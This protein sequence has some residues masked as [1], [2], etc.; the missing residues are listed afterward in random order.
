MPG[1][2]TSSAIAVSG[3]RARAA[4]A[5]LQETG[6]RAYL[7]LVSASRAEICSPSGWEAGASDV[8]RVE[9]I[10]HCG[11]FGRIRD[12][13]GSLPTGAL[14]VGDGVARLL[15]PATAEGDWAWEPQIEP[16]LVGLNAVAIS[17]M[18]SAHCPRPPCG[19]AVGDG[20]RIVRYA[21]ETFRSH[22]GGDDLRVRL[23]SLDISDGEE[24]WA[25]GR[26]ELDTG[27]RAAL[28]V[29]RHTD[30]G[31]IWFDA[32]ADAAELPEL[33]DVQVFVDGLGQEI[34]AW[35]VGA[36]DGRGYF[37]R[38]EPDRFEAWSWHVAQQVADSPR[39]LA[40]AEFGSY[41]WAFGTGKGAP[42]SRP[43]LLSWRY[44]L[45][46]TWWPAD[47]VLPDRQLVDVYLVSPAEGDPE[48]WLAASPAE[49]AE[50]AAPVVYRIPKGSP[51]P[52]PFGPPLV[53]PRWG[54]E[55]ASRRAAP[56]AEDVPAAEPANRALAPLL[57]GSVLYA[58]GD[59]VWRLD[60][61]QR[62]WQLVRDRWRL[63]DLAPA[64]NGLWLL[65]DD[66]EGSALLFFGRTGLYV[67]HGRP[68]GRPLARLNALASGSEAVWAVGNRGEVWRTAG[69]FG[70][71]QPWLVSG[72]PDGDLLDAVIAPTGGLWVAGVGPDGRGRVWS[73]DGGLWL[74][75][76]RTSGPGPLVR[77]AVA[78]DGAIWA[79]GPGRL[80]RIDGGCR[81]E[82][83]PRCATEMSVPGSLVAVAPFGENGVLAAGATHI[84][85]ATDREAEI[86]GLYRPDGTG[87]LPHG[88]QLVALAADGQ[89]VWAIAQCC[90]ELAEPDRQYSLLLV[91][92]GAAWTERTSL[93]VPLVAITLDRFGPGRRVWAVGDWTTVVS[94]RQV[95]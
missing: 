41:G 22:S 54:G 11:G 21:D 32:A 5:A 38:G 90:G 15:A 70:D 69:S 91:Y 50:P 13:Y 88:A 35:A 44:G 34:G 85:R 49:P 12:L 65:A 78:N 29:L 40:L 36:H 46:G 33:S 64:L 80:L 39:E 79:V 7:P 16:P 31:L 51:F 66:G 25:V 94:L 61:A 10:V 52:E 20:D 9:P 23:L 28:R 8:D 17:Q 56:Q 81:G 47:F 43:G 63:R 58:W 53:V 4:R 19:W 77:L 74:E 3:R 89:G 42:E 83:L 37:V 60:R 6:K 24:G 26:F 72:R 84:V 1:P 2:T 95:P 27:S 62:L 57:D 55:E 73:L 87:V 14:A 67:V 82:P 30:T 93:A 75:R 59:Y 76:A 48:V 45:P 86:L 68:S 71:W 18:P 92:D